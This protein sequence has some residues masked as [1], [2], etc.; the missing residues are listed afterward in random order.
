MYTWTS[1]FGLATIKFLK[2]YFEEKDDRVVKL[3]Y[4]NFIKR[5]NPDGVMQPEWIKASLEL[6]ASAGSEIKLA[7]DQI[8]SSEFTP[9]KA[10]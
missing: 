7:P 4:D 9:I 10:E 3:V 5:I 8:F 1:S 6:A 2:N